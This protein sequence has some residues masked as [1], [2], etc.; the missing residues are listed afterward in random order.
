MKAL[1]GWLVTTKVDHGVCLSVALLCRGTRIDPEG[2]PYMH[3]Y[4]TSAA[5]LPTTG[6]WHVLSMPV[7]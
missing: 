7:P 5:V 2:M 4:R 6:P 1:A 3:L